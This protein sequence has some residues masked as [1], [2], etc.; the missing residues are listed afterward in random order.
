M[1]CLADENFPG[2]AARALRERGDDVRWVAEESPGA[3][4]EEVI[5]LVAADQRILLTFDK[6]FG[7]IVRRHRLPRECGIIL[8]R[9]RTASPEEAVAEVLKALSA[10][11]DWAGR[12]AVVKEGWVRQGPLPLT[13][14]A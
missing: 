12:F 6:D 8:F 5:D 9:L 2:P 4:D 1:K 13:E 10:E 3:T 11:R 7:E 14:K